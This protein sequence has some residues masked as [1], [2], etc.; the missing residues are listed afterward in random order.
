M[1]AD[2]TALLYVDLPD[3]GE[4]TGA[5]LV[6]KATVV[7]PTRSDPRV[8]YW[9]D[10]RLSFSSHRKWGPVKQVSGR[11]TELWTV[12]EP[13]V[14]GRGSDYALSRVKDPLSTG[15]SAFRHRIASN[16]P[17]WGS[18]WR[19]EISANWSTDGTN[20]IRGNEYWMAWA[21]KFNSDMLQSNSGEASILDF[22]VVPDSHDSNGTSP[23]HL[24]VRNGTM[25]IQSLSNPNSVT[26]AAQSTNRKL[27]E[28]SN[29]GDKWHYFV[30][31]ARFHWDNSKKPYIQIW[32]ATGTGSL[33]K[34]VDH[35]GPNAYND[36]ATYLP[37][38]FGLYRYDGWSGPSTRTMYSKG[39]Y[40]LR[41]TSG[42]P[43]L[44]E[45]SMLA[46]LKGV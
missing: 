32:K 8:A 7:A 28:Q 21:V 35:A 38:K 12:S 31:K 6:E 27:W 2:T 9:V 46:L 1:Y 33:V 19:S 29:A 11:N 37:Q 14:V 16:F 30:M 20:V 40:V 24:F 13:G 26:K 5:S 34:I 43:A 41:A 10:P 25:R 36:K 22:H 3:E 42:T 15:K 18:T 45:Q 4:N 39:F 44:N 23:F 17:K